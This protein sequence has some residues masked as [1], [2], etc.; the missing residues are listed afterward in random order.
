MYLNILISLQVDI[1]HRGQQWVHWICSMYVGIQCTYY[2]H[3]YPLLLHY[4]LLFY[5]LYLYLCLS[6]HPLQ[7]PPPAFWAA[8]WL[9]DICLWIR[10]LVLLFTLP[11]F[12]LFILLSFVVII[13]YS[14]LKRRLDYFVIHHYTDLLLV[15][16]FTLL[17]VFVLFLYSNSVT[18]NFFF[19]FSFIVLY[20]LVGFKAFYAECIHMYVDLFILVSCIFFSS[21][22]SFFLLF[23]SFFPLFFF[24]YWGLRFGDL[25]WIPLL[26]SIFML[27]TKTNLSFYSVLIYLPIHLYDISLIHLFFILLLFSFYFPLFI[28]P[29]GVWNLKKK[30]SS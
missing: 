23:L 18:F 9:L 10:W 14:L 4:P 25:H 29:I 19:L 11:F 16:T 15:F 7:H 6:L 28:Q 1:E 17:F 21:F 12:L 8:R 2:S 5:L 24:V 3:L 27:S 30:T 22:F 13:L 26:Q 20:V